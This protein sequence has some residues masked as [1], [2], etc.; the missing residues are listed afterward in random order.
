MFFTRQSHS[1]PNEF[2]IRYN[3]LAW[4]SSQNLLK[5]SQGVVGWCIMNL[6]IIS[7]LLKKLKIKDPCAQLFWQSTSLIWGQKQFVCKKIEI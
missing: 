2:T 6:I 3:C 1:E 4:I 7:I 5:F